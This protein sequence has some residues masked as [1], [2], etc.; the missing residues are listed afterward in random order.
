MLG[1]LTLTKGTRGAVSVPLSSWRGLGTSADVDGTAGFSTAWLGS[2]AE[3]ASVLS[4]AF[5]FGKP[6]PLFFGCKK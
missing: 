5:V 4:V 2:D 1:I 3:I 6:L